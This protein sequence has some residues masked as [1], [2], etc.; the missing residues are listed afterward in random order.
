MELPNELGLHYSDTS[1]TT[2]ILDDNKDRYE[3]FADWYNN[4]VTLHS[5]KDSEKFNWKDLYST[6]K[7]IEIHDTMSTDYFDEIY[8]NKDIKFPKD[9]MTTSDKLILILEE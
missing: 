3:E 6:I 7:N 2:A 4:M 8:M 1:L 9:S 5:D